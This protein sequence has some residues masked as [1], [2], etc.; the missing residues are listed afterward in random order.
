MDSFNV[1]TE[2]ACMPHIIYYGK[3]IISECW[4][5]SPPP[6]PHPLPI[7]NKCINITNYYELNCGQFEHFNISMRLPANNWHMQL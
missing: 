4:K 7:L 3:Y 1:N 2:A 6:S 5:F